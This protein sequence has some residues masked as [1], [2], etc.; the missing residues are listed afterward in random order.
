MC[1]P[2]FY[3]I[4]PN[5]VGDYKLVFIE[6]TLQGSFHFLLQNVPIGFVR[7]KQAENEPKTS[8]VSDQRLSLGEYVHFQK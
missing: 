4:S 2:F 1:S 5:C 6:N 3:F 8:Y 7:S